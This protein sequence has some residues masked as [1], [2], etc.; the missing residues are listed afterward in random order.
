MIVF[1]FILALLMVG[2]TS[3]QLGEINTYKYVNKELEK[4]KKGE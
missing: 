4:V 2:I 3:Y 1:M